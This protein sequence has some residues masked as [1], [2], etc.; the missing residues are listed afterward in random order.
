MLWQRIER[1]ILAQA[2]M[3]PTSNVRAVAFASK[4]VGN[5]KYSPQLGALLHQVWV[6]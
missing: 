1:A 2:P 6:K 5:Y 3:V 4:R